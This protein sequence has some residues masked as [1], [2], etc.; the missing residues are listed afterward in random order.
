LNPDW[1]LSINR[2]NPKIGVTFHNSNEK[3]RN[4]S[5]GAKKGEEAFASSP[6]IGIHL[7][8]QEMTLDSDRCSGMHC[9]N[10]SQ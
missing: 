3:K 2:V 7:P 4:H 6:L 8:N 1:P 5:K 9:S 10:Q